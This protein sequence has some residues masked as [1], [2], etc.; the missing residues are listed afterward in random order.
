MCPLPTDLHLIAI[1]ST[2]DVARTVVDAAVIVPEVRLLLMLRD[3]LHDHER[4]RDMANVIAG[5]PRPANLLVGLN[6]T[7]DDRLNV[8]HIPFARLMGTP[9][10][11]DRQTT[12]TSVH[13][14][15]EAAIAC[16][17][18]IDYLIAGPVYPTESKPGHP[19]IGIA[20]LRAVVSRATC[21]VYAIGG[22]TRERVAEVVAVG[23]QGIAAVS[24]FRSPSPS[25]AASLVTALDATIRAAHATI[26]ERPNTLV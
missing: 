14:V 2:I 11:S 4:S 13:S 22:M 17:H 7:R 16:E 5:I 26:P 10:A 12:G 18:P 1:A 6:S 15:E 19:G 23:A 3:P 21:P 25:F 24:L 20:G 9:I 8:R